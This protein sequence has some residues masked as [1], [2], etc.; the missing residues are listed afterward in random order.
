MGQYWLVVCPS[1]REYTTQSFG[2]KLS[3]LLFSSWSNILRDLIENEWAGTQLIY[4]FHLSS[5]ESGATSE[6]LRYDVVEK[7]FGFWSY[8]EEKAATLTVMEKPSNPKSR[9]LRNLTTGEYFFEDALPFGI[10]IGH[11]VLMSICWSSES[12]T[13]ITGGAYLAKGVWA[14]HKFDIV[15]A[16]MVEHMNRQWE[17]VTEDVLDEVQAL[18]PS[19]FGHNSETE[20]RV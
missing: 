7:T 17:D 15:D 1:K 12:S 19:D 5:A 14:G 13:G 3:E 6:P 11:I 16:D 4:K 2:G 20:W 9:V 10:T 8:E 18:W